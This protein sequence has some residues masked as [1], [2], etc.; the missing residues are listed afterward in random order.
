MPLQSSRNMAL[1]TPLGNDTLLLQQM[2]AREELGRPF[3]YRIVALSEDH[4]ISFTSLLGEKI[5]VRIDAHGEKS[6]YFSGMVSRFTQMASSGDFA[7]YEII[8]RPWAWFLTRN[9]DCRM[10]QE[11]TVPEIIKQ[12][13]RDRGFSDFDDRLKGNYRTWEY[14]VQYRETDFNFVSRLMEQEGIYYFFE[15]TEDTHTLVMC[16]SYSAH[17]TTPDYETMEFFPRAPGQRRERDHLFDWNVSQQV[18]P[19]KFAINDFDFKKPKNEL[20]AEDKTTRDHALSGFEIYDYPGEYVDKPDGSQYVQ[21]RNE[22]QHTKYEQ[23]RAS[24]DARGLSTGGLFKLTNYPREDQNKEYLIVSATYELISDSYEVGAGSAPQP[25]HIDITVMDAEAPFRSARTTAK[26]MVQGPQTAVVV[27]AAGE[28]IYCD[29]YGRVKVKF[30]WDRY[31]AGD[32]TSSCWVRVAQ[33]WAGAKWGSMHIPRIGQEV[34]VD[35]LEGDPDRPIITGRVYNG[36][37]MPHYALPANQT[38]SG[39]M[40]RSTKGGGVDNC[41][42]IRFE[43][44]KDEEEFYVHAEKD[45]NTVVENNQT[46]KVGFDDKEPGDRELSV[47]NDERV[48]IGQNRTETVGANETISIG[49]NRTE[50]VAKD[51]SITIGENRTES[52]G[53]N[54]SISI[55]DNRTESVGSNESISVGGSR[56]L[57]VDKDETTTISANRTEDVGKNETISIA[58]DRSESVGKGEEVQVAKDRSHSIGKNDSLDVG[59]NLVINAGDS[60]TLKTGSATISMKKDGTIQIKGKDITIQGSGKINAKASGAITL[61]GSKINQN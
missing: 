49:A 15:H 23:A 53:S 8:A 22:E 7:C 54:E 26:P 52:V 19:G 25:F 35:F 14:C 13:F 58:G 18:Q 10:F 33:V 46:I 39:L 16:D 51:E 34:I 4:N 6:R 42:E 60:I 44:K 61:K 50:D 47:H 12:V 17:K 5:G 32:E 29:E 1:S 2:T 11:M 41:N 40:S 20:L 30:H 3:E 31:A 9:S 24:G 55:G 57:S 28:E 48:S 21:V 37:N 45:H 56:T 36:D 27:G 43:D 38:R 59:K